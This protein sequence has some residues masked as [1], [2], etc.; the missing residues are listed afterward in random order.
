MRTA[1]ILVWLCLVLGSLVGC[2][3]KGDAETAPPDP[4][5]VKAQQELVARRDALLAQKEKLQGE[6]TKIKEEI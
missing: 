3:N 2:K 6:A 4:A 1:G 5:A